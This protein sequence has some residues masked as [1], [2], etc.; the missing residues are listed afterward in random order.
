MS[1]ESLIGEME[2]GARDQAEQR[3][4]TEPLQ[5]LHE[6][7]RKSLYCFDASFEFR[8]PYAA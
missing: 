1:G 5:S 2:L 3:P 4:K 8:T 7:N 6:R